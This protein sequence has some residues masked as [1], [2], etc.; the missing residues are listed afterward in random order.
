MQ[1]ELRMNSL[2]VI[3]QGKA[4]LGCINQCK[5]VVIKGFGAGIAIQIPRVTQPKEYTCLVWIKMWESLGQF[6]VPKSACS[7]LDINVDIV[8]RFEQ[9]GSKDGE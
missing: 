4:R 6:A 8:F 3:T 7:G 9:G 2:K 1:F 5:M